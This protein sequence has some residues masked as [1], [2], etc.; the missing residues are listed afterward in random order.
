MR[1][2]R[3]ILALCIL[4]GVITTPAIL[5]ASS[6]NAEVTGLKAELK[7]TGTV[8]FNSESGVGRDTT[9]D[10]QI[11]RTFDEVSY[12]ISFATNDKSVQSIALEDLAKYDEKK[13]GTLRS[14]DTFDVEVSATIPNVSNRGSI[15]ATWETSNFKKG[16]FELSSDKK[17]LKFYVRNMTVGQL[18]IKGVI[19]KVNDCENGKVI[20][21][22]VSAKIVGK[23]TGIDTI[24][25]KPV[26]VTTRTNLNLR[27]ATGLTA[28]KVEVDGSSG[29][30]HQFVLGAS[31]HAE[32]ADSRRGTTTPSGPIELI[33]R[34]DLSAKNIST[35]ETKVI[36]LPVKFYHTAPN[37]GRDTFNQPIGSH[38]MPIG[39]GG[40][41]SGVNSGNVQ[42]EELGNNRFK[43]TLSDYIIGDSFPTWQWGGDRVNPHY[44]KDYMNFISQALEFFVPFYNNSDAS[45]DIYS[46]A[47]IESIKYTDKQGN[48][49]T[50]ETNTGDNTNTRHL[51]E[52]LPGTL[53]ASSHYS[54]KTSPT[55]HSGNATAQVNENLD[56]VTMLHLASGATALIIGIPVIILAGIAIVVYRRR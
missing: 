28:N 54:G 29:R 16:D 46:K 25:D 39:T 40:G 30:L 44:K 10:D 31:S 52:Y 32:I 6:L 43:V 55:W 9:A 15:E 41:D 12:D 33:L 26:T 36:D 34:F 24:A 17:T 18:Y 53:S 35:Q 50:Q 20:Q 37:G 1:F 45:Y 7:S 49:L 4:A 51:P 48:I 42:V 21:P 2:R 56:I 13:A 8:P 22:T 3:L 23:L 27:L 11:V 14:S 5:K 38:G 47:V 19:L